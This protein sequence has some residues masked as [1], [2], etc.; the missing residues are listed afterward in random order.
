MRRLSQKIQPSESVEHLGNIISNGFAV[1]RIHRFEAVAES[2]KIHL[3]DEVHTLNEFKLMRI[4]QECL[5][6]LQNDGILLLKQ[7]SSNSCKFSTRIE[8]VR[9]H[10]SRCFFN[11]CPGPRPRWMSSHL[12]ISQ[13]HLR[14][15]T[16]PGRRRSL[17]RA[18]CP[19]RGSD[20]APG[21]GALL[22]G[23]TPLTG[24]PRTCNRRRWGRECAPPTP[25]RWR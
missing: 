1:V 17:R 16:W 3:K 6:H 10:L 24:V 4:E 22:R 2:Q 18:A 8:Y 13:S 9:R 7:S 5:E 23:P 21:T 19:D 25:R 12:W 15:S 20:R 11:P 14:W